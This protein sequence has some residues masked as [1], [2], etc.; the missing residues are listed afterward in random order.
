MTRYLK[1]LRCDNCNKLFHLLDH[2][3]GKRCLDTPCVG[4][5]KVDEGVMKATYEEGHL[6]RFSWTFKL[7]KEPK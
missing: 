6:S 2:R 4:V 1:A 5:L 3:I 7:E